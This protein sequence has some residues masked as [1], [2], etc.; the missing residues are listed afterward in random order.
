MVNKSDDIPGICQV[1]WPSYTPGAHRIG[2][3]N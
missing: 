3:D 2:F 1:R